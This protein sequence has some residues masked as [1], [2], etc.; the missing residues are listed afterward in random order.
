MDITTVKEPFP[1]AVVDNF[2][3]QEELA[4]LWSE[5]DFL[6]P[7][8][9][10]PDLTSAAKVDG[11]F[12]KNGNGIFLDAV[13]AIREVSN[14]L[15]LSRKLYKTSELTKELVEA[16]PIFNYLNTVTRNNTLLNCYS[17]GGYYKPHVDFSTLSACTFLCK[18]QDSFTGGEFT[19]PDF[20]I[21]IESLNNRLVLFPGCIKHQVLPIKTKNASEKRYSIAQFLYTYPNT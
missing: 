20:D 21:S 6:E 19:F 16:S 7:K 3:T 10:P 18:A 17:D 13:Y 8:L 12:L 14:L 4:L 5:I 9:L 11:A 2:Y 15:M 1:Y